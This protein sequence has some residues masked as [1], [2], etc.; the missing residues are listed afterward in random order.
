MCNKPACLVCL[1][2][3]LSVCVALRAGTADCGLTGMEVACLG[4]HYSS[5]RYMQ[6]CA[7]VPENNKGS[8]M[9]SI[10]DTGLQTYRQIARLIAS[11]R[12]GAA[13]LQHISQHNSSVT[14][15]DKV[16]HT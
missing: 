1:Q 7:C 6:L 2:A 12:A 9:H 15:C 3:A 13:A 4:M 16:C 8:F 14:R 10:W 11:V 5:I